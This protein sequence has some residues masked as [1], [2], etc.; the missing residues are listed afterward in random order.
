MTSMQQ[1]WRS[2]NFVTIV[3]PDM[4]SMYYIYVAKIHG[5]FEHWNKGEQHIHQE[6]WFR[7]DWLGSIDGIEPDQPEVGLFSWLSA[8]ATSR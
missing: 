6:A 3:S 1:E 7:P 4:Y 8:T 2:L 5:V